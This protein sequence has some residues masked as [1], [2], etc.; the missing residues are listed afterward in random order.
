MIIHVCII[1]ELYETKNEIRF[2][3][4]V[5]KRKI[6]SNLKINFNYT[7]DVSTKTKSS[8]SRVSV[9]KKKVDCRTTLLTNVGKYVFESI[10]EYCNTDPRTIKFETYVLGECLNYYFHKILFYIEL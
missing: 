1:H 2:K 6:G 3:C 8:I 4:C 10:N 9:V 7:T 5:I